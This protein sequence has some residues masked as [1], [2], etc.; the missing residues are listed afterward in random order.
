VD[1]GTGEERRRMDNMQKKSN[2]MDISPR[3]SKK[4]TNV[5]LL[6]LLLK[7]FGLL[8]LCIVSLFGLGWR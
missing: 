8:L 3:S 1:E 6:L 4:E 5:K 2:N 7:L